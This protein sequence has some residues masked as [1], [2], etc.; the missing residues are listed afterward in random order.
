M[1]NITD[2]YINKVMEERYNIV[3]A[4]EISKHLEYTPKH[5]RALKMQLKKCFNQYTIYQDFI[6]EQ[7]TEKQI[8]AYT[9]DIAATIKL[10]DLEPT[11]F[12]VRTNNM[13]E[14]IAYSKLLEK[15]GKNNDLMSF[16][17]SLS[18][19]GY[20][21]IDLTNE[22]LQQQLQ[23][24]QDSEDELSVEEMPIIVK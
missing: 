15:Q 23:N 9:S 16:P 14:Y 24:Y 20:T 13:K 17:Y 19:S 2:T 6:D 12:G 21:K 22:Y 5:I 10:D 3:L 7:F 4:H 18:I 1:L 11:Q 8:E